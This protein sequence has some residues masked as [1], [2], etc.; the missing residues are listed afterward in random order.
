MRSKSLAYASEHAEII[1][2]LLVLHSYLDL[3][4]DHRQPITAYSDE[5]SVVYNLIW[6]TR[7]DPPGQK[8]AASSDSSRG[9]GRSA[10]TVEVGAPSHFHEPVR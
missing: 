7:Y 10:Q 4:A 1:E 2:A 6:S 3:P 9:Y 8:L 5:M